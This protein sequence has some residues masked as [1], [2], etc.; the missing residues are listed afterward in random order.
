VSEREELQA[1]LNARR[2]L[3]AE[4]EP[5]IVDSFLEKIERRLEQRAGQAPARRERP[6]EHHMVTPMVLGSLGLAIPLIGVAGATAGLGGVLVVAVAI[7]LVNLVAMLR[8]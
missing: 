1:A 6:R 4:Y 7:V 2:E 3:G 8:R 5:Q